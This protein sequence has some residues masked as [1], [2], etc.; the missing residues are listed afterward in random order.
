MLRVT[1]FADGWSWHPDSLPH[2]SFCLGPLN[3]EIWM[4]TEIKAIRCVVKKWYVYIMK[5]Y[6]SI[7]NNHVIC[8][9]VITTG[10]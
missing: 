7:K 5:F 3:V 1:V 4:H 9:K 8:R 2:L 10:V 6:P